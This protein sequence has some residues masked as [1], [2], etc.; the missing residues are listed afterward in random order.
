MTTHKELYIDRVNG[1]LTAAMTKRG[2]LDDLY[3]DTQ[4]PE[5][6]WASFYIGKVTKIDKKLD[7]AI[8][9]LGNGKSGILATKH[10]HNK[11]TSAGRAITDLLSPGDII[12]VQI[13]SEAKDK[14]LQENKKL[15]RLTMK[16]CMIGQYLN[17][18]PYGSHGARQ[19]NDAQDNMDKAVSSLRV[20]GGWVAQ[21]H[22]E[23]ATTDDIRH[24]AQS[25]L[26]TWNNIQ[27]KI[28]AAPDTPR[29]IKHGLNAFEQ[30]LQDYSTAHFDHIYC[31]DKTI[32]AML[33]DWASYHQK[34]LVTSK[35]LR[36]FK[37]EK[38]GA[39]L[40]DDHDIQG[41][42]NDLSDENIALADGGSIIIEHTH[43]L[44]VIDVNQG[45][46]DA[47]T[48]NEAAAHE[49]ARQVRL[50]NM[51]GAILVDFIGLSQKT[52]RSRL[53]DMCTKAFA[54]DHSG[55]IVHGFSR[56]G[57]MEITRK[58]RT[59]TLLEKLNPRT[60]YAHRQS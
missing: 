17:Y 5:T 31:A 12:P 35:R 56:L 54:Q 20:S 50:R 28:D 18:H 44:T 21:G 60:D 39:K 26:S 3:I 29:L 8:V 38:I 25:L 43:A 37:P 34:D 55:A 2:M 4:N 40:F 59:A 10:V 33:T 41:Q 9:D 11:K 51:S 24:E 27:E 15:P 1:H 30:A 42:I 19:K 48:A 57:L 46:G 58:R 49:I 47:I 22:A 7:A 45:S 16:V 52:Y 53:L 32:L 6:S 23:S 13:K 14:T 36:L